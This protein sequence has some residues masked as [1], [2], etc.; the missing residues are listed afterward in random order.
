MF[1]ILECFNIKRQKITFFGTDT[2][3]KDLGKLITGNLAAPVIILWV[4]LNKVLQ[5]GRSQIVNNSIDQTYL[6]KNYNF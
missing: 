6:K 4:K 5:M 1:N 3:C 2:V